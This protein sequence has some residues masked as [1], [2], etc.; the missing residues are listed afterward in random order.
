M[1]NPP[2]IGRR[3]LLKSSAAAVSLAM[4]EGVGLAQD[5]TVTTAPAAQGAPANTEWRGYANDL[6]S[7]RYAALDQIDSSNF[8]NLQVAWSFNSNALGPRVDVNWQST[9][10]LAN[11]RLFTTAGT[12]RDV[13][14]LHP[15][16]GELLW[17]YR[18]DEG[19]RTGSRGG[20]GFGCS[21][22][23]DGTAERVIFTTIGYQMVSLDA[24]TG[25]LDPGFGRN[26]VVDLRDEFDQEVDKVKPVVGIHSAPLVIGTTIV[27]GNA[28][29]AAIKGYVR[30]YDVLTGR[31]KWI[32]HTIP[33]AGEF[34]ADTWTDQTQR[35]N[36]KNAGAW[37]QMSA[38]PEL[39]LV[40]IP[41]ELPAADQVGV[42]RRGNALF[43]ESIVAVD[44]ETGVRRWHYQLQ[45][46]GL[47]DRDIPCAPILC[48]I[49]QNGK[50]IKALAQ[51][52]KQ[53]FL[54]V[55]DRTNG[56]P[57]WPIPEAKVTPGD[58]PGEWY[59][60]TQPKPSKPPAFDKQG[61]TEADL[62]DWTPAIKARVL[63]IA[64]HYRMGPLWTAPSWSKPGGPW[65][66]MIMPGT[67][68]GANWG[69]ASYDPEIHIV[70][71]YSK[72]VL[73]A[74]LIGYAADGKTILMIAN[75][76][77]KNTFDAGGGG[78][79]GARARA[80]DLG[81]ND[82]IDAPIVPELFSIEGLP[83][84]KPP[85][86]RISALDLKTGTLLWQSVH[87]ETP[88]IIK[89]H[90]LLKGVS[91]PRTGQA[92]ILGTLTTR[93]LVI[94]GDAGLF[95]DETGRKGARLR[96]YDKITGREVGAVFSPKPQ[97]GA[98]MTYMFEGRQY[99]VNAVSTGAGADLIAYRLPA[100][101]RA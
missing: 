18:M 61:V 84:H 14:A 48:D 62:A 26:G 34:G 21:Y 71:V 83:I 31:R 24:K 67:Q 51:P 75:N 101:T 89:N 64:R 96:A 12:R 46:H 39:G 17:I 47:W 16:T 53:A 22:W 86:G 44:I 38:D 37:A 65:G 88:D 9:P 59:S 42:T 2:N 36:A 41:V 93:T 69:G 29:T 68:G 72:T 73:E 55:L 52:T 6:A 1:T 28:P 99:I 49:P 95:T 27:V 94:C 58:V 20:P 57:V 85:Y 100:G 87:G 54:Y 5:R 19:E 92:G 15:G 40:Y 13:L 91:I 98:A 81:T 33:R 79:L 70:Y 25:L 77:S 76:Q 66:T 78:F 97:T 74:P 30:A 56:K 10:I 35:E 60:P 45:H 23:T 43:S 90:R 32:F 63:E 82:A 80:M 11:G 8:N 50:V 4:F 7:T 3:A